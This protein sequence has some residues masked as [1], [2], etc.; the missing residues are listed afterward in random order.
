M[1]ALLSLASVLA[2]SPSLSAEA[3][4]KYAF[5]QEAQPLAD[6]LD[7]FSRVTGIDVAARSKLLAGKAAPALQ[8]SFAPQ[9]ALKRLL[10]Q[11]DLSYRF[12]SD[13]TVAI[14]EAK[15]PIDLGAVR[16]IGTE[17][18]R[19]AATST[20]SITGSDT[21]LKDTPRSVQVIPEQFLLDQGS[22]DLRDALRNVSGIHPRNISGGTTDA[23][24]LRGVEVTSIFQDGF[25]LSSSTSRI[26]TSN[27]ERIE[28]VKGPS[29]I[30]AGSS[31]SGGL[32]NIVSKMPQEEARHFTSIE[33]DEF[34]QQILTLD[35]TDKLDSEGTFLYRLVASFEDSETFRETSRKAEIKRALIAP[36]LT[37]NIDENSSFTAGF[38]FTSSELPF[39]NGSVLVQSADDS[40]SVADVDRSVRFGESRDISDRTQ[41]TL[42]LSYR[43]QFGDN[44]TFQTKLSGQT[45][46]SRTFWTGANFGMPSLTPGLPTV[47]AILFGA[48]GINLNAVPED[49]TL[50]R[51]TLEQS[52]DQERYQL[53]LILSGETQWAGIDHNLSFR[54]D[55]NHS[56]FE[57]T[58][59]RDFISS[60]EAGFGVL[61]G[62]PSLPGIVFSDFSAFD[63]DNPTYGQVQAD[64]RPFSSIENEDTQ[65]GFTISDAISFSEQWKG[66][67]AVRFDRFKRGGYDKILLSNIP[68]VP[69]LPGLETVAYFESETVSSRDQNSQDEF[70]PSLGFVYQP[71]EELGVFASYSE[72]FVPQ[73]FR[74]VV[75]GET[76]DVPPLESDQIELGLKGSLFDELVYFNL[77]Y[78]DLGR[79]NVIGTNNLI[80]GQPAF[81]DKETRRGFE[82]DTNVQF[83]NGL[84]LIFNVAHITEAIIES[85]SNRGNAPRNVPENIVN[86]WAT[87]EFTAGPMQGFGIGGGLNYIGQR[88]VDDRNTLEL[89]SYKTFDMAAYYYLPWGNQSQARIQAGIK[90]LGDEEYYIPNNGPVTLGVGAPRTLYGSIGFEF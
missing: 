44:W 1:A 16:L 87:Y 90:N 51:S 76:L 48:A 24:L 20:T 80:T 46:D 23:F 52:N 36:S 15:K 34:G 42:N 9:E 83:A 6:A 73:F 7:T 56:D 28:V 86:L 37:W 57:S 25:Q 47:T 72:S 84:S 71:T 77:A 3:N 75:T 17:P 26:Q 68:P 70:S 40:L 33:W 38:E 13:K 14:S 64:L 65:L 12:K 5:S 21:S 8:G 54:A 30:L 62:L 35:S 39:D 58:T 78:F 18:K 63:I 10:G 61:P 22:T 29:A 4:A 59:R 82:F 49:G 79:K 81:N 88:F 43:K 19:Y 66:L 27:I 50:I 31:A 53:A 89:N 32:I 45:V 11:S 55:Y 85:G 60:A 74:N 41:R 67:I 69:G 2:L